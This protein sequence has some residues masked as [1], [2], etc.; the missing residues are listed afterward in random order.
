MEAWNGS[1]GMGLSMSSLSV[2]V[3]YSWN[4]STLLK[5]S[6]KNAENQ[7]VLYM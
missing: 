5:E 4:V 2:Y 7:V 3:R 6:S 1:L